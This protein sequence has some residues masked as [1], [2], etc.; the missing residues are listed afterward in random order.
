MPNAFGTSG[1]NCGSNY[2]FAGGGG[3]TGSAN[4]SNVGG[5]GGGGAGARYCAP[6][7]PSDDG[8]AGTVNTGCGR[9]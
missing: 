3:G 2:Y 8:V 9:S 5:L 4:T 6:I 1:Q 7:G